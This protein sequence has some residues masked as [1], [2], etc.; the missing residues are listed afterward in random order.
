MK[1]WGRDVEVGVTG[2]WEIGN[3]HRLTVGSMLIKS[4]MNIK[5]LRSTVYKPHD[6]VVQP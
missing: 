4:E 3:E 5:E 6:Y 2:T 1:E